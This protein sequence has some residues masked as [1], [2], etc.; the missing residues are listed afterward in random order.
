MWWHSLF[1]LLLTFLLLSWAWRLFCCSALSC[2]TSLP[3]SLPPLS[4]IL[5]AA[6]SFLVAC[7]SILWQETFLLLLYGLLLHYCTAPVIELTLY[8]TPGFAPQSNLSFQHWMFSGD[9][10]V[11]LWPVLMSS[12]FCLSLISQGT[13][14]RKMNYTTQWKGWMFCSQLEANLL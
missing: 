7:C 4:I 8:S 13:A 1:V 2:R 11:F 6:W 14:Y 3:L 9:N 5:T 10:E 12:H